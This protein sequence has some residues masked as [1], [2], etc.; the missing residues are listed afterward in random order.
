MTKKT[1]SPPPKKTPAA[2]LTP[3]ETPPRKP[4]PQRALAPTT[5]GIVAKSPD[6]PRRFIPDDI[7]FTRSV[8]A[9]EGEL[10]DHTSMRS[11][12]LASLPTPV[13]LEECFSMWIPAADIVTDHNIDDILRSLAGPQQQVWI[14]AR[15]QVRDFVRIPGRVLSAHPQPRAAR[16]EMC[17]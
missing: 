1:T 16:W 4:M 2:S 7:V 8:K 5:P 9:M 3:K 6:R 12:A 15:P 11:A 10:C 14:D 17:N 13:A